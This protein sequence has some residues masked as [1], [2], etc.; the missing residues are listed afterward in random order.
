M[1]TPPFVLFWDF[2]YF[3]SYGSNPAFIC[4]VAVD[5]SGKPSLWVFVIDSAVM[6]MHSLYRTAISH[7]QHHEQ[8]VSPALQSISQLGTPMSLTGTK[9]QGW[10]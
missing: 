5:L 9:R 8:L 4:F 3:I 1:L 7:N 2:Y 6:P 10:V